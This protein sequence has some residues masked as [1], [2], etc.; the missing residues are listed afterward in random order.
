MPTCQELYA[1]VNSFA[2]LSTL[3]D[4]RKLSCAPVCLGTLVY[5]VALNSHAVSSLVEKNEYKYMNIIQNVLPR[6]LPALILYACINYRALLTSTV[7]SSTLVWR[8]QHSYR[9]IR[10]RELSRALNHQ[11]S[12][13]VLNA[14]AAATINVNQL[15]CDL[16]KSHA[17]SSIRLYR[18]FLTLVSCC[19]PRYNLVNILSYLSSPCAP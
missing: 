15:S 13:D 11:P 6:N 16:I 19:Q 4:S 1:L 7:L 14:N 12:Y 3:V 18:F 17:L 2:L 5:S 9:I 10:S 8:R